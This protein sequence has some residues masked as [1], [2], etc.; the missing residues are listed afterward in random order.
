MANKW[1]GQC[2]WSTIAL[3][4]R[5]ALL[6]VLFLASA[7]LASA[8]KKWKTGV[9][10]RQR[11]DSPVDI[12]WPENP[13]RSSLA[14]LANAQG[15]AIF[16]D[17]RLDPQQTVQLEV[18]AQALQTAL[19]QLSQKVQA[20]NCAIG[21]LVYFAP[22]EMAA[23]LATLAAV[24]RQEAA[25]LPAPL[26]A[27]LLKSAAWKWNDLA[28]PRELLAELA[29]QAGLR[30]ENPQLVPHDLWPAASLPPLPLADRL[31][32]LL[33]GFGL[34]YEL[35]TGEGSLRLREVPATI[36]YEHEYTTRGDAAKLTADLQRMFPEAKFTRS[37]ARIRIAGPFE[38][39]EKIERLLRGEKVRTTQSKPGQ[40]RYTLK[41]EDQPAG[42]V[43]KAM[44]K[45]LGKEMKY[46]PELVEKLNSKVSFSL[47]EVTLEDL[48][49]ATLQPL[50]LS[51]RITEEAL[52]I[53]AE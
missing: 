30:V 45:D 25:A 19:D 35:P 21:S 2:L 27:K 47:Q 16:L 20:G 51:Y 52:E 9:E 22:Q 28:T 38:D 46:S 48:L 44:A 6:G 31:T 43:I 42:G 14:N 50:G 37:G 11:L 24:R 3:A 12:H 40:K 39:H 17:R 32:V 1:L 5:F 23:K 4:L 10:F 18:Q 13:L 8:E 33:A 7:E 49:Q 36:V 34:T 53:V 29:S 41:V 26:K 15:V